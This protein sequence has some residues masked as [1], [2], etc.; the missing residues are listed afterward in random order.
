M[1]RLESCAEKEAIGKYL[2][3]HSP[4]LSPKLPMATPEAGEADA[5]VVNRMQDE[6]RWSRIPVHGQWR[7][8]F[9][10]RRGGQVS[11]STYCFH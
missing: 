10:V 6:E 8:V 4:E 5:M 2:D 1:Q 3:S 7:S 11:V 9:L